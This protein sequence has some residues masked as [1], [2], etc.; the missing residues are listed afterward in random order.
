M[1]ILIISDP[2]LNDYG[3]TRPPVL[4]SKILADMH[5]IIIVST[6]ISENM[7]RELESH[8]IKCMNLGINLHFRDSSLSW[9]E[10][11]TRE[12][13][14]SLNSRKLKKITHL[15]D[16]ILNFSNTI[17]IP[18]RAWFLQGPTAPVIDNMKDEMPWHYKLMYKLLRPLILYGDKRLLEHAIDVSDMAIANSEFCASLYQDL[19]VK[20]DK[21]VYSPIDCDK[22]RPTT[23]KPSNDYVLAYFGKE[24]QLSVIRRIAETGVHIKA[25]GSKYSSLP[26]DLVSNPNIEY[27]GHVKE[28]KLIQLY[29]NASFTVFPFTFEFLGYVPI[30]SMSCGTPVLTYGLQGPG[31]VV[32][33][34]V[35]GWLV[36]NPQE[37]I[38]FASRLFV[39]GYDLSMRYRCREHALIFDI[40]NIA[41]EWIEILE[42]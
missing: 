37:M 12:A 22:F 42:A 32:I 29:S 39:E 38:E 33:N 34:G 9:F 18:S 21:T 23:Q 2:I 41:R 7:R 36:K 35:T 28:E 1:R 15:A 19:G 5:E 25:F 6:S 13:L 10:A 17:I 14:F 30:E 8:G 40:K 11:W 27:L 31:E 16:K 20:I 3:P 24:T 4:L 26:K